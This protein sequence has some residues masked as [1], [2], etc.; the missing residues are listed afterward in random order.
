LTGEAAIFIVFSGKIIQIP[1]YS[2]FIIIFAIHSK[3]CT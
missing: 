3:L 2:L 1:S